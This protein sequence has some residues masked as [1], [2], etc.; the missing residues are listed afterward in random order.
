MGQRCL[1]SIVKYVKLYNKVM[2]TPEKIEFQ[3]LIKEI[4]KL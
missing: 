2:S 1:T 3:K 4:E